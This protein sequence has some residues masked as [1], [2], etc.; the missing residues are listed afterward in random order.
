MIAFLHGPFAVSASPV[1][2]SCPVM[3]VAVPAGFPSPAEDWAEDRL[4]L[5]RRFIA[6]PESTF[7]FRVS[8]DSM[9][10]PDP[11][12]TIADGATLVV[13]C[14]REARHDDIVVAVIDNDFTVKRLYARGQRL[15]LIAEN[16]AFPP[17]VLC[18]EQ[19]L[20]IWGVVV[21]WFMEPR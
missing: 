7:F 19:E 14:R 11:C 5:N 4:D 1:A 9:V 21:A 12:R 20:S 3:G 10:S 16:P 18:E 13:D 15:A 6:H 17:I 8:G 2:L